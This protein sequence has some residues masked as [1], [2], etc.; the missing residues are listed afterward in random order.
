M[1][2]YRL[3]DEPVFPDAAEADPDGLL[4]I[5]GDLSPR[6]LVSAYAHGIFPWYAAGS[7]ILWW[8]PDPRLTLFPAE[9]HVPHSL[10]RV[11]NAR[12][13]RFSLDEAFG[14]VIRACA[15]TA[16]PDQDGTWL[17]PDMIHAYETLHAMGLAHSAEAWRDGRLVG[18]LYGVALGAVFFG[19]SMFHAEPDASKAL[20]ATL[21]PWL[22]ARGC[23]LIDCQQTTAHMLRFG[24]REV[25]RRD[26]LG[27]VARGLCVNA[28]T[29]TWR[30]EE[31]S[32]GGCANPLGSEV[33]PGAQGSKTGANT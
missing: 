31:Q 30:M 4:A 32:D 17:V 26:F 16:R 7:P 24:A 2:I 1:T 22:A 23:Q 20:F 5:G 10:R 25:P 11:L 3:F 28:L 12:R 29:G 13:F 9:L 19:E 33:I 15:Q 27:L 21:A 14:E 8:S 18:G 6:R